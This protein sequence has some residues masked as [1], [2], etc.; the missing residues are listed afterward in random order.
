ME[1]IFY[2]IILIGAL[3]GFVLWIRDIFRFAHGLMRRLK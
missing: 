2:A 1:R 3:Y